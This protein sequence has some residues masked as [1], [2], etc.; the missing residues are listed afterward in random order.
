[1]KLKEVLD[2]TIQFFKDKNIESARLDAELLLAHGLKLQRIQLYL[3][4]D[5]PLS[6]VEL[7]TC[8]DLVRRRV[9]GEPV[10][11][12][13]GTKEFFGYN[14]QVNSAVLIPRPET[15][16]I[17]EEVMKW[18]PNEN[19]EYAI[20]DLGT[21][22]GCIGLTLLKKLPQAKLVAVDMSEKALEV[23]KANAAALE[24][25]DRVQFVLSD[26]G[27]TDRV[28][29]AVKDFMGT[30]KIDILVSN[31]PYIAA[32]DKDVE[33]NVKKFEPESAL[34]APEN[35]LK[36]LVDWSK[37]YAPFLNPEAIMLMEMGMSQGPAMKKSYES[38]GVFQTVDIIKDLAGLDRVI[39]GVKNG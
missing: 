16:H 2:K 3:K 15:E 36:F 10:A 18:S 34:F 25:A 32:D 38:L 12:I 17:I 9:Q 29:A 30:P 22:S 4:F 33:E 14:F 24:V 1:M 13:L 20:V 27:D 19:G 23:A 31:P 39:R 6:D 7:A 26:A 35:G 8:R 5:Q 21:G 11:Y 28:L 37:K